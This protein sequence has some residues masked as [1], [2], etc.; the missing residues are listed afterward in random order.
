MTELQEKIIELKKQGIKTKEIAKELKCDRSHIDETWRR[1]QNGDEFITYRNQY[2]ERIN[3]QDYW[4]ERFE[5]FYPAFEFLYN[6]GGI[7]GFNYILCKYC[8]NAFRKSSEN[9]KPS[10]REHLTC[11]RCIEIYK[12]Y[13]RRKDQKRKREKE[14]A[15]RI[16]RWGKEEYIK[17]LQKCIFPKGKRGKQ[18]SMKECKVCRQLFVPNQGNQI[19]CSKQCADSLHWKGKEA[20]RYKISL[21]VLYK[22]DKGICHLCGTLCDWNDYSIKE[23][24][25]FKVGD[26]YP[27][28]DHLIPKSKGGEHS[29]EN[30]ALA[31]FRCN[32]LRR[33][34]NL[35][36]LQTS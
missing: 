31:H 5:S 3:N 25:S 22:R 11:K 12:P 36:E 23:D 35:E 4:K 29:Y 17:Y 20:Y 1:Y 10:H 18:L 16:S 33:D 34:K 27:T 26:N 15:E 24:G 9:L 28:R 7:E 32:T 13:Q 19:Y 14:K 8:G 2:S 30:I 6:E 21:A